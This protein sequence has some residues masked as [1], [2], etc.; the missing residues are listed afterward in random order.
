MRWL[1]TGAGGY[2]GAHLLDHLRN[3]NQPTIPLTGKSSSSHERL[4]ALDIR[5]FEVPLSDL[6]KLRQTFKSF[7]PDVVVHLAALKSPE[8]S[9]RLPDLY[10][11]HNHEA[12]KNVFK[13]ATEFDVQVFINASSS[14]IYGDLDS[15]S[16]RESDF[17]T[18]L[19]AYGIS[20]QSG[21]KFLDSQVDS[22]IKISSLRF[23]NVIGS[24]KYALRE[25]A[26]FHLVP[27]TIER[28]KIGDRPIIFGQGLPTRDGTA[29]RDYVHVVDAVEAIDKIARLLASRST[30]EQSPNHLKVN[31]GS[32][33]GTSVLEI[34]NLIQENLQTNLRPIFYPARDGDPISSISNISLAK[35]LIEFK[36]IFQLDQMIKSCIE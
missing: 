26:S 21:E 13:V 12:L 5:G 34:V 18:P 17:G 7:N 30:I 3:A 10:L 4:R 28:L 27:A 29:M 9:N 23:F 11:N 35:E 31:I 2:I 8:E 15:L 32:G 1:I 6:A 19:S 25:K 14:S 24:K 20:K 16:I 22:K 36:P 33:H